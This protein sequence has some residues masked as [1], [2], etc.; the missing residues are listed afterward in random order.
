[1]VAFVK[2]LLFLEE[3]KKKKKDI[4]GLG[5]GPTQSLD[6]TMLTAEG[7]YSIS[8][9]RSNRKVCLILSYNGSNSSLFVNA[10]KI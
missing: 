1:M 6:N 2:M 4:F 10:T 5:K 7:R 3:K 8:F 9:S